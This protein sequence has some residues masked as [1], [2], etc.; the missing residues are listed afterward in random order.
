MRQTNR[1]AFSRILIEQI[2]IEKN[3]SQWKKQAFQS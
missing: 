1:Q 2:D 3:G